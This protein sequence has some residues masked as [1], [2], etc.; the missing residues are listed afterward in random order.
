M[1]GSDHPDDHSDRDTHASDAGFAAHY[2]WVKGYPRQFF[3]GSPH[4][5]FMLEDTIAKSD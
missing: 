4:I 2:F 5:V 1:T 3:H